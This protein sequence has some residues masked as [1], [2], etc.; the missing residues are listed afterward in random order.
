MWKCPSVL[1]IAILYLCILHSIKH[2]AWCL[3]TGIVVASLHGTLNYNLY[4]LYFLGSVSFL[5]KDENKTMAGGLHGL[6]QLFGLLF[7]GLPVWVWIT[8]Q[9]W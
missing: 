3:P 6:V 9:M 5:K 2:N 1:C 4:F 7:G 8:T